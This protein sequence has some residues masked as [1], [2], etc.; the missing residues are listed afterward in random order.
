MEK[1]NMVEK[2]ICQTLR[3]KKMRT[4]PGRAKIIELRWRQSGVA[5][6]MLDVPVAQMGF[7]C[8]GVAAS[9]CKLKF[10]SAEKYTRE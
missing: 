5:H 3:A 1:L 4:L 8:T 2:D 9:V 7:Q 6:G 10:S